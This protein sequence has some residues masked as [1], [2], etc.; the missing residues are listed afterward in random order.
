MEPAANGRPM[1]TPSVKAS[2]R[3]IPTSVHVWLWIFFSVWV[4][5]FFLPAVRMGTWGGEQRARGW[6]L[7]WTS[8]VLFFVPVK[9]T[10]FI[11]IPQIWSVWVNL[12]MLLAP[13]E[14]K[15]LERGQGRVYAVLFSIAT[16]IPVAIAYIPHS[17]DIADIRR[18]LAGFYVWDFSMIATAA[19]FVRTLWRS[20]LATVPAACLMGLLL[21]VPVYRGEVNFLPSPRKPQPEFIQADT[22]PAVVTTTQIVGSSPNPSME[23]N[24]VTF[25]ATIS[26]PGGS[27]PTGTVY[28]SDGRTPI[29]KVHTTAGIG[30][31][32]TNALKAGEHFI[33]ANFSGDGSANYLGGASHGVIQ[34][35]NDP[36][37]VGTQTAL[38]VAER[39]QQQRADQV[40]FTVR[41]KVTSSG[42]TTAV[43][44]GEVTFVFMYGFRTAQKLDW[45]GEATL[46]SVLPVSSWRGYQIEAI[47]SGGNGLQSSMST[48]TLQ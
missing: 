11:F 2:E 36:S 1:E 46:S 24:P 17:S 34:M 48:L 31:F 21:A 38:T 47:Y 37:D 16:V 15:Q 13:F 43:T 8:F 29:G 26:A 25:T 10:F 12:F 5:S 33:T 45:E 44:T 18:F 39:H 9:G 20:R 19:L 28:F 41:A 22:R 7:A 30:S 23:G 27:T 35:V 42:S 32:S 14:I 4:I 40:G 3:T 6:E